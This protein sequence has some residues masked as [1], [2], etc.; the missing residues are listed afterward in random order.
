MQDKFYFKRC[1][2]LAQ[3]GNRQVRPN[4]KVGAV[5]VYKNRII[6][7]G[8]HKIFGSHHAEVN[9]VNSVKED[10]KHLIDKSTIYV[11]LEP[12]HHFGATPPCVDLIIKLN[13]PKI[14][15]A[16]VDPTEKVHLKSIKKLKDLGRDV[17]VSNESNN[18]TSLISE[19]RAINILKRPF[20]QIKLA[21]S[22]DNYI[23]QDVRQV[24]LT[25]TYT[26][27]YTHKL[28]AYTDAILIG[29][30]TA[31]IDNP[32]LTLRNYPGRQPNRI[33]LD[34]TEKLP[35]S[36]TLLADD[37]PTIVITEKKNYKLKKNKSSIV[38]DFDSEDFLDQLCDELLTQKIY[39]I[40]VEG[41]AHL[42]KSFIKKQLWDEAHVIS[43]PAQLGNG[44]KAPNIHGCLQSSQ[45][46]ANN[47]LHII[48]NKIC[49]K[50]LA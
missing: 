37:L 12:C 24:H 26:N 40:M 38:L 47:T 25:N 45:K 1:F 48:K 23:G 17:S 27:V 49:K 5:I 42:I 39:H 13:I 50:Q 32:S 36:L 18:A 4:P 16:L 34:R 35:K 43:T 14:R 31:L 8:Y 9:A 29:T 7:E 2:D 30:N 15:I 19:F 28:R 21:K 33:I 20:I 44:V 11:S 46:I 10:D 6:G 22:A 41:G 3:L